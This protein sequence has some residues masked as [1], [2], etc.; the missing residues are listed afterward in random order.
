M[1]SFKL[2]DPSKDKKVPR[3][4]LG[5]L[6]AARLAVADATRRVKEMRAEQLKQGGEEDEEEEE[7]EG[8]QREEE[9]E[10]EKAEEVCGL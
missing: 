8:G 5:P 3:E 2:A 9:E 7:E 1:E 4:G 10:E 6:E